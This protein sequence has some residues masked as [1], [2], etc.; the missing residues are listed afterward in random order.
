LRAGKK[1]AVGSPRLSG[2]RTRLLASV[3]SPALTVSPN[4]FKS[5]KG[6]KG[7]AF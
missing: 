1:K 7:D 4:S 3:P 5:S 2:R 6:S